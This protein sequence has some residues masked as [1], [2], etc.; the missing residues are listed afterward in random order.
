MTSVRQHHDR[1]PALTGTVVL[2]CKLHRSHPG[3]L[4]AGIDGAA[5]PA[6]PSDSGRFLE[7]DV[8]AGAHVI[9]DIGDAPGFRADAGW[10]AS[11]TARI[12]HRAASVEVRGS[13]PL[14]IAR[15]RSDLA[16]ALAHQ[17]DDGTPAPPWAVRQ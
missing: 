4:L 10:E 17:N 6:P 3:M 16:H 9:L 11:M 7:A 12:V 8:L 5:A 2:T 14:G 13:N 1:A 15:V